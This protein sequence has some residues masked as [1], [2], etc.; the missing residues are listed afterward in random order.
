M[1]LPPDAVPF[2]AS[3][4][5]SSDTKADVL[6]REEIS[7]E[8]FS[9]TDSIKCM[10]CTCSMVVISLTGRCQKRRRCRWLQN[11]DIT[12]TRPLQWHVPCFVVP[13]MQTEVTTDTATRSSSQALTFAVLPDTTDAGQHALSA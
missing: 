11:R 3:A 7:M 6:L 10:P 2:A 12:A 5:A 13:S 8:I 9:A 1:M 4:G